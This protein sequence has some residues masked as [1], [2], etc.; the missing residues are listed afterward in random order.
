MLNKI[1]DSSGAVQDKPFGRRFPVRMEKQQFSQTGAVLF[2][3]VIG[4]FLALII[5]AVFLLITGKDP[6]TIY[7]MTFSKV[8][9]DPYGLAAVANKATPLMLGAAG[10][11]VAARAGLWNVGVEGQ[12]LIG[13]LAAS[14][15]ALLNLN[16]P[17]VLILI[18]MLIAGF[19][20]GAVLGFL[21][22]LPKAYLK[23]NEIITTLLSN[24]IV[25]LWVAYLVHGPMRDPGTNVPQSAVFAPEA[26]LPKIGSSGVHIGFIIAI[27]LVVIVGWLLRKS[28]FGFEMRV[29]G[30]NPKAA[31][32]TGIRI[33]RNIL[34]VMAIS[35][36]LAGI[37]GMMEVAGSVHRMQSGIFPNFTLTA[38]AV[39]WLSR[40]NTAGIIVVS[41]L[42]AGLLVGVYVMQI[43][44]MPS[45]MVYVIEGL[46]IMLV[47]GFDILTYYRP[48]WKWGARHDV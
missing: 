9:A 46:I 14:G 17:P 7:S 18:L 3:S 34:I 4:V 1:L 11:A 24:Y 28:T 43:F 19:L 25:V 26:W 47:V 48:K 31:K 22:A 36:G 39:A 37:G 16:I 8:F 29:V 40:L 2:W 5:G 12:F 41:F 44:G 35:G 20:G 23:V 38:F 30:N 13:A 6:L 15:V 45:A 21:C 27:V 32:Y 10:V 42:F 33:T